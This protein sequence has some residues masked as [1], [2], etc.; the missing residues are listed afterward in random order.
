MHA[1]C[2]LL[3]DIKTGFFFS[4]FFSLFSVIFKLVLCFMLSAQDC[5][6][7]LE[8][9]VCVCVCARVCVRAPVCLCVR[10]E[11]AF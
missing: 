7:C 2:Y 3:D 4:F 11:K 6:S 9:H 1:L 5:A 10:V 8:G